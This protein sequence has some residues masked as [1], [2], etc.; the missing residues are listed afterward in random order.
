VTRPA[1]APACGLAPEAD[2]S[3]WHTLS[4]DRVLQAEQVDGQ[5]GLSSAEVVSRTRPAP[6]AT[7][8][9]AEESPSEG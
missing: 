2:G 9:N 7:P 3:V 6:A 4:A 8:L 5:R 1:E